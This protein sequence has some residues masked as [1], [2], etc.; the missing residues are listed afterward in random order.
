MLPKIH[1]RPFIF[2]NTMCQVTRC[3][4]RCQTCIFCRLPLPHLP[5]TEPFNPS[6]GVSN[7]YLYELEW[8]R[9]RFSLGADG[10]V[11]GHKPTRPPS[12][13]GGLCSCESATETHTDTRR[14]WQSHLT[15]IW[16]KRQSQRA[17]L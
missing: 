4:L 1:I 14:Q 5:S 13:R 15:S 6:C 17:L 12:S 9:K 2:Q 7:G 16:K 8:T 10:P 11:L 3:F